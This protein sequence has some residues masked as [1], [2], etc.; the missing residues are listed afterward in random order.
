MYILNVEKRD[1]KVKAKRIR[2]SGLVPCSVYGGKLKESLLF[3]I[4]EGEARKL[5]KTKTK[6]GLVTLKCDNEEYDVLIKGICSNT[7]NNKIEDISFQS[8]DDDKIVSSV[9]K[10]IL[11]NKDKV[12]TMVQLLLP[13]VPYKALPKNI[14]ETIEIDISKLKPG[15]R[16]KVGDL[17]IAANSDRKSVV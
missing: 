9:A 10:I 13:E 7:I 4:P 5:L 12:Q 3:T 14:V 11:I 6:G 15:E 1:I 2:K 16:V 8:L 17:P